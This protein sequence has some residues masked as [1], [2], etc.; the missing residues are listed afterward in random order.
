MQITVIRREMGNE[1][2]EFPKAVK[3]V[4]LFNVTPHA[5]LNL[6]R[7]LKLNISSPPHWRVH[8]QTLKVRHRPGKYL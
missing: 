2:R 6:T 8:H 3:A 4:A 1:N 7:V 5:K